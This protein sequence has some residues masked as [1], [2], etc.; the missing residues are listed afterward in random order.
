MSLTGEGDQSAVAIVAYRGGAVQSTLWRG[1]A[2]SRGWG[3]PSREGK[4]I[5]PSCGDVVHHGEP[6]VDV[7]VVCDAEGGLSR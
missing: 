7:L 4:G 2:G 6:L 3:S 5:L 1:E